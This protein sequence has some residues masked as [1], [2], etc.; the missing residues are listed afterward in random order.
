METALNELVQFYRPKEV[1][2]EVGRTTQLDTQGKS[3]SVFTVNPLHCPPLCHLGF[4]HH[5]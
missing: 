2:I 5:A 4:R 3:H 1:A